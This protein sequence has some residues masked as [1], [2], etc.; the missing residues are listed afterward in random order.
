MDIGQPYDNDRDAPGLLHLDEDLDVFPSEAL[1]G[2]EL[3]DDGDDLNSVIVRQTLAGND[4]LK[5]AE[6]NRSVEDK[7]DTHKHTTTRGI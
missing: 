4:T 7:D 1:D 6:T 2:Q 3:E 5:E